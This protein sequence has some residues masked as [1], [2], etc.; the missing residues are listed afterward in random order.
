MALFLK[1]LKGGDPSRVSR[2]HTLRGELITARDILSI[3]W[4]LFLRT[5]RIHR[6]GPWLSKQAIQE[7]SI[8]LMEFGNARILELGGGRSSIYFSR[9]CHSLHTIEENFLWAQKIESELRDSICQFRIEN[10]ELESRLRTK[11]SANMDYDL[12]LI[13]GGTDEF[14]KKA[15]QSLPLLNKNA[16]YVLDNSDRPIFKKIDFRIKPKKVVRLH[17]LVRHPFQATET[18]F[19][20]F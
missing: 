11:N 6:Q 9:K 10:T 13:D 14:R 15:I 16:I 7:L 12:V 17:G 3:P 2:F 18:T 5:L 1:L 4:E 8:L 19:F 20:W